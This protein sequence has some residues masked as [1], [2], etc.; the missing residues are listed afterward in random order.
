MR[1]GSTIVGAGV[2]RAT[3]AG[4]GAG[5]STEPAAPSDVEARPSFRDEADCGTDADARGVG[6]ERA[7]SS[8]PGLAPGP[9]GG[10]APGPVPG[11]AGGPPVPVASPETDWQRWL[12]TPPGRYLLDW[13][14][15]HLDEA[16]ADVFGYHALQVGEPAIDAL[17]ANRMPHRFSA[18]L[19]GDPA[20][21][22]GRAALRIE[23][24]EE[25]PFESQSIDLVVLPHVLEFAQDPHQ[26]L[27]EVDRVLRP[28]GR[29]IVVG[30]N[31]V[32]LWGVR[33]MVPAGLV[34]PF[35]PRAAHLIGVPRLRDWCKLLSFEAERARYGCWRPPCRTQLWLDR[36]RFIE[37]AG[38]RW[39]PICG[40]VYLSVAIKRVRGM[41]LIGPAWK[42]ARA[43]RAIGVPSAQR[44]RLPDDGGPR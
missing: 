5:G 6:P 29:V 32:S 40:A 33:Q 1:V 14:Q 19:P 37:R 12:A 31:P 18:L 34:R 23:H 38:D 42:R 41:R 4:A 2:S 30:F 13:V 11:P 7:P 16:V 17:R 39:W 25:L 9:A 3:D 20:P 44:E 24:P 28:E 22:P 26:V 8:A 27:R 10:P 35:V 15:R 36:T 43:G 21:V